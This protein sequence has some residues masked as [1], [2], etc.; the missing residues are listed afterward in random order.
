LRRK[1]Y[2]ARTTLQVQLAKTSSKFAK[3]LAISKKIG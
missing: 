3:M 2:L 1:S